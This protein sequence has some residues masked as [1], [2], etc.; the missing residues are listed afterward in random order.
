MKLSPYL[1]AAILLLPAAVLAADAKE[2]TPLR[3]LRYQGKD[4]PLYEPKDVPPVSTVKPKVPKG[5]LR[6]GLKAAAVL[7]VHVA[8]NGTVIESVVKSS[9]PDPAWGEVAQECVRKWKYPAVKRN[10]TATSY[11][12]QTTVTYLAR[13]E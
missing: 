9:A 2:P 3:V 11:L 12:V 7:L 10:G 1:S 8:E 6:D 5:Y 13:E 4:V